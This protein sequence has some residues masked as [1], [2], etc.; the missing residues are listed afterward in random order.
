M[1][2]DWFANLLGKERGT[3]A[4]DA[5]TPGAQKIE[6]M[7][8]MV[9]DPEAR[10]SVSKTLETLNDVEPGLT[11]A[12][13][14][15]KPGALL[16]YLRGH[17]S[18]LHQDWPEA[19]T[20]W[21][22]LIEHPF[23]VQSLGDYF[24]AQ[25]RWG[26]TRCAYANEDWC[27]ALAGFDERLSTENS[28]G[29]SGLTDLWKL[30]MMRGW[31][32]IRLEQFEEAQ[33]LAE[34]HISPGLTEDEAYYFYPDERTEPL[35]ILAAALRGKGDVESAFATSIKELEFYKTEDPQT[36]EYMI[37]ELIESAVKDQEW[38]V[39]NVAFEKLSSYFD[40]ATFDHVKDRILPKLE[41]WRVKRTSWPRHNSNL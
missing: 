23:G 1:I 19:M 26:R 24:Q 41:E 16:L 28:Q 5:P 36:F 30:Q 40:S 7:V 3:E 20:H 11:P 18:A 22:A 21:D 33:T 10:F 38:K 31:C 32:F 15:G 6:D 29:K 9:T 35:R 39:A 25:I 17:I 34:A 2:N 13:N 37:V 12:E 27:D 14:M 4:R 8:S